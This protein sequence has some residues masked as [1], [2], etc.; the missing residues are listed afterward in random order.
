MLE[1]SL[2]DTITG[3][4]CFIFFAMICSCQGY[5]KGLLIII[6]VDLFKSFFK[7]RRRKGI[8]LDFETP[9][10]HDILNLSRFQVNI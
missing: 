6:E 4:F 8:P 5:N 1:F 10:M 3:D 2:G 9:V 7:K